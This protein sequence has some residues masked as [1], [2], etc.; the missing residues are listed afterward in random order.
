M[1]FVLY[2]NNNFLILLKHVEKE[3]NISRPFWIFSFQIFLIIQV[4]TMIR[5]R[6]RERQQILFDKEKEKN[7]QKKILP[8]KQQQ[9]PK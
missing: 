1:F 5:E 9:Q 8:I 6:E 2:N 4:T 3:R 7:K